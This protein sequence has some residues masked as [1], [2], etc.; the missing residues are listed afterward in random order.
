MAAIRES[1]SLT[2]DQW[3]PG[4]VVEAELRAT[5]RLRP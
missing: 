1:E 3:I 4:E 2:D 5:G